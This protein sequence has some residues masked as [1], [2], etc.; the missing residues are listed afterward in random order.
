[1]GLLLAG[2]SIPMIQRRI[3]PNPY[4][5]FRVPKAYTS[6]AVWYE[7]NA[8]SGKR[9]LLAG[10]VITGSAL[11]LSVIPGLTVDLYAILLLL[12]LVIVLGVGLGQSF[13]Y[14]N[15]IAK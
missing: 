9:L 15:Q 5:G 2:L 8:Y 13:V 7:I 10:V 1:M 12:V 4:Y 14:L 11:I 3:K 6:D